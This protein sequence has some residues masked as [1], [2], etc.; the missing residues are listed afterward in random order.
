MT[1]DRRI[2]MSAILCLEQ[3]KGM[4]K[5]HFWEAK[6]VYVK[7]TGYSLEKAQVVGIVGIVGI[8]GMVGIV[9]ISFI[10]N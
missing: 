4:G 1:E 7:G 6:F 2:G 8:V 3:V 5:E 9:G 10:T